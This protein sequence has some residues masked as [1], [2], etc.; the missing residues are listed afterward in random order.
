MAPLKTIRLS[1]SIWCR[2]RQRLLLGVEKLA[3]QGFG[4]SDLATNNIGTKDSR[5]CL[6]AGGMFNVF[7]YLVHA[8][9]FI[10]SVP[11]PATAN[12]AT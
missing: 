12:S 10:S 11:M 5:L 7:S 8:F 9:S 1:D 4:L 3:I 2:R 6:F